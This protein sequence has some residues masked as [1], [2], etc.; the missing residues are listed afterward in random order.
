MPLR[1][2]CGFQSARQG[3]KVHSAVGI[4]GD[5]E[6][7]QDDNSYQGAIDEQFSLIEE[8]SS[9]HRSDKDNDSMDSHEQANEHWEQ[10]GEGE[11]QGNELSHS[12]SV[13]LI[14]DVE[15]FDNWPGHYHEQYGDLADETTASH[16]DY[17]GKRTFL[18]F[19]ESLVD[20]CTK[21]CAIVQQEKDNGD[22]E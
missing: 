4:E 18:L 6:P 19:E 7:H 1:I 14:S 13:H 9:L 3:F 2:T 17:I 11:D 15:E 20:Y 10:I 12:L 5:E 8:S 21:K 16:I 22:E